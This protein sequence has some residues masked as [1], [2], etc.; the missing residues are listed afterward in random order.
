MLHLL[1]IV[2]SP[3]V[4]WILFRIILQ[5][6][7]TRAAEKLLKQH[8]LWREHLKSQKEHPLRSSL[9][10]ERKDLIFLVTGGCGFMGERVVQYLL[11][12]E[13]FCK[14][15]VFDIISKKSTDRVLECE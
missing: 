6:F 1:F 10:R 5:Y 7:Q 15:R 9:I 2:I 13:P 14:I 3:F 12:K 4:L 11:K 8:Y